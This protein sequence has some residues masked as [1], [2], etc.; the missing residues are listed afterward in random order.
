LQLLITVPKPCKSGM[1]STVRQ[2]AFAG[3]AAVSARTAA[4]AVPNVNDLFIFASPPQVL[5]AVRLEM[6]CRWEHPISIGFPQAEKK[7]TGLWKPG[8]G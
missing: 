4:R 1:L 5:V 7:A 3:L 2:D 8:G 6:T